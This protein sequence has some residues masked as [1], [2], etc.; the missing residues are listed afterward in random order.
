MN[1]FND[2][3][4]TTNKYIKIFLFPEEEDSRIMLILYSKVHFFTSNIV[5]FAI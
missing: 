1:G 4:L 2:S 5:S 3:W